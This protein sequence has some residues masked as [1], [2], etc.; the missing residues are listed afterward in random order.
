MTDNP[1]WI[2]DLETRELFERQPD[3]SYK[4]AYLMLPM[5]EI[6]EAGRRDL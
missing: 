5:G 3:G 4:A 6:D 2:A 1:R